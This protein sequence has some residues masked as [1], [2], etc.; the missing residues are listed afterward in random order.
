VDVLARYSNTPG[1]L[2]DLRTLC[3]VLAETGD[4]ADEPGLSGNTGQGRLITSRQVTERLSPTDI[5][6]LIDLYL[7]GTTA[8][9]LAERFK[10][11]TTS[12]KK[13]LR[14]HGVRR[15]NPPAEAA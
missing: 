10:I 8:R 13:L 9:A 1:M 15:G 4:Q 2:R 7:A 5:K 14:E 12:V 11:G 6:S 3:T